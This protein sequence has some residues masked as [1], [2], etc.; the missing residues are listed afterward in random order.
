MRVIKHGNLYELG[1]KT[2]P[3]CNCE[4]AFTLTDIEKYFDID[5]K[6]SRR[7]IICPECQRNIYLSE[8]EICDLLG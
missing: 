3:Y 4:F 5:E 7:I 6:E 2:C 8:K 1:T